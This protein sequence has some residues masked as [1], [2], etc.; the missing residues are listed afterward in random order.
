MPHFLRDM[1]ET[2]KVMDCL[3]RSH[4]PLGRWR[5]ILFLVSSLWILEFDCVVEF[6][7]EK[8]VDLRFRMRMRENFVRKG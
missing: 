8:D 6:G 1:V 4:H 3:N 2:L 7:E 5:C